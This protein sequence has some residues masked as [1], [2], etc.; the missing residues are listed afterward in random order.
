MTHSTTKVGA[1]EKQDFILNVKQ[2]L[3]YTSLS[4]DSFCV[5]TGW[6][7]KSLYPDCLDGPS[8]DLSGK[9]KTSSGPVEKP[10]P[11]PGGGAPFLLFRVPTVSQDTALINGGKA[12]MVLISAVHGACCVGS[13]G[14]GLATP[15]AGA[16]VGLRPGP[17][18]PSSGRPP[19]AGVAGETGEAGAVMLFLARDGSQFSF[20]MA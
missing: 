1:A 10:G 12:P 9:V 14:T 19:A 17:E 2:Q 11:G 7:G 15:V 6:A 20:W 18:D 8:R 16:W 13:R 3:Q 4:L 5:A